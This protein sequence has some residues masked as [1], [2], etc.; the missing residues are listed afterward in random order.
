MRAVVEGY[1]LGR[2]SKAQLLNGVLKH[3][4][5]RSIRFPECEKL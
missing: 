3:V 4:R 5:K 1:I 2:R